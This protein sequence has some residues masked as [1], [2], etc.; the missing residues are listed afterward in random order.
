MINEQLAA[1]RRNLILAIISLD[2]YN[3]GYD[4]AIS[5]LSQTK[6]TAIGNAKVFMNLGLGEAAAQASGF[7]AIAYDLTG[8]EGFNAGDTV[9]SYRGTDAI[10][11]RNY[12]DRNYG[13]S[14]FIPF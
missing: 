3:R 7:Y 11:G 1:Q 10:F 13:D 4:A 9:I 8:V 6:D 2:A 12:G 14:A 5:S